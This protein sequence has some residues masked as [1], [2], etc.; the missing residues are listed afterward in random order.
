M[1]HQCERHKS[2]D[3][4]DCG[5]D[6]FELK[7]Y[8]MLTDDLWASITVDD[9]FLGMLC[10]GCAQKR[11]GR[12]LNRDDFNHSPLN[13]V[14][15]NKSYRLMCALLYVNHE[16]CDCDICDWMKDG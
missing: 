13:M 9:E 2:D 5:E 1:L 3:C 4:M 7:E 8:Y 12:F 14:P 16:K 15:D 6:V 10:F 11:A